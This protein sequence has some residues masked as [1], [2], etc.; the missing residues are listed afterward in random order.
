MFGKATEP[1]AKGGRK[2]R[3][4]EDIRLDKMLPVFIFL[5]PTTLPVLLLYASNQSKKPHS[6]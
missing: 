4:I 6:S 2:N 5:Y 1:F 3:K